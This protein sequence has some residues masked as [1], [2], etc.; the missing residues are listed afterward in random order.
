MGQ[1]CSAGQKEG[2]GTQVLYQLLHKHHN[3]TVKDEGW[4]FSTPDRGY[5]GLFTWC[6]VVFYTVPGI[7]LLAK[8]SYR[9]KPN[10]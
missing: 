10:P 8:W 5:A 4:V 6:S 9:R 2:W 3:R 7:R 1:H